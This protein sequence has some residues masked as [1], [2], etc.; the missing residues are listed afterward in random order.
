VIQNI[1]ELPELPAMI[2]GGYI[3]RR[4][5]P[6]LPLYIYNYT[7]KAQYENVW[8]ETTLTCRGLICDEAGHIYARPFRKF[9]NLEQVEQLPDEPFEVTEKLDGSL[10]IMYWYEGQPFIATRGSFDSDQ[11]REANKMLCNYNI[12]GLDPEYTYLFEIIYPE[13]RIVV[14]Y[15]N[16]RELVML[17]AIHTG[18]GYETP[19]WILS[20]HRDWPHVVSYEPMS[21]DELRNYTVSN[22]EGFVLRFMNGL[23]VKVKLTEYVRLHKLL[24][25]ITER[26]IWRDYLMPGNDIAPL[27]DRV[28]DEFNTWLQ[29]TVSNLRNQYARVELQAH[30]TFNFINRNIKPANRKEFAIA[31]AESSF[32][33]ILFNM[34]DGKDYSRHIWKMV[35]P[36]GVTTFKVDE[37]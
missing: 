27:L 24:T 15:G 11:A 13:N 1:A 37:V 32:A 14:D 31:A 30:S 33:P 26:T 23:R 2:E 21:M 34:L 3:T 36:K 22:K 20:Q 18:S 16:R 7:A 12:A 35:E 9:F 6:E 8:N 5:H 28:P 29:T 10:G 4:K 25:G 17:A 19:L